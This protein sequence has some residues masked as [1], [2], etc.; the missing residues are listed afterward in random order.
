[1]KICFAHNI[2]SGKEEHWIKALETQGVDYDV[3][4]L[5]RSDWLENILARKY[6]LVIA[7][8]NGTLSQQKQLFDERLY[9]I[10]HVLGLPIYPAY[11]PLYIYENKRLLSYWLKANNIPHPKTYVFYD[12]NEA[13]TFLNKTEYPVVAKANI[14]AAGSGV[15]ILKSKKKAFKILD[16]TFK[17][18]GLPRRA[19]P[20]FQK[21]GIYRRIVSKITDFGFVKEKI[22]YYKSINN[23]SQLKQILFQEFIPHEYEWRCVRIGESYFFHKKLVVNDKSSGT[24]EKVFEKPSLELMQ[25]IKNVSSKLNFHS[26]V[27]DLFEIRPNQF[28]VNEIQTYFGQSTEHLMEIDGVPGRYIYKD[29]NWLFE[30][31]NFNTNNSNDLRLKHAIHLYEKGQLD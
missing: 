26:S 12:Y 29:N 4:L 9:I 7:Q 5:N 31:G 1:M 2:D 11:E 3:V 28:Y 14:G 27:F 30:A 19:G 18:N 6:D 8:P 10:K 17:G 23:D 24:L 20:N 13:S 16:K 22:N 25:F 15:H 21:K